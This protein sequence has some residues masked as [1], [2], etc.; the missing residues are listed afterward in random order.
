[1]GVAASGYRSRRRCTPGLCL[2]QAVVDRLA[3][4]AYGLV[5]GIGQYEHIWRMARV[6]GPEGIIVALAQRIAT[7][8]L[9]E[10][11]FEPVVCVGLV[12]EAGHLAI[13]AAAVQR[14]GLVERAIR[15]EMHDPHTG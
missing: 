15:L 13:A 1:M 6:R 2:L 7:S 14:D 8:G 4:D 9:A 11:L 12:V 5:G 3:E 10:A